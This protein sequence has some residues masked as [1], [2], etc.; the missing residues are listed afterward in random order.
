L[1]SLLSQEPRKQRF[2]RRK[3]E[4]KDSNRKKKTEWA[5]AERNV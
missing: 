2:S 3:P 4:S 5:K 1:D